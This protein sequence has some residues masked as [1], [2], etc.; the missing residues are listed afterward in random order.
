[1]IW[2]P[3]FPLTAAE[4]HVDYP[5]INDHIDQRRATVER[6]AAPTVKRLAYAVVEFHGL[7]PK[8]IEQQLVTVL[9]RHLDATA[10]FGFEEAQ[11]E[12]RSLRRSRVV[13]PAGGSP[14]ALPLSSEGL[15]VAMVA[16]ATLKK[17]PRGRRGQPIRDAGLYG[18]YARQGL[19]GVL[20]LI[21]LRAQA[22]AAEVAKVAAIYS[23]YAREYEDKVAA[24]AD[25][26][27]RVLHNNVLE[28][29]GESVNNGRTAGALSL[30]DPPTFAM[31]SE[32]LDKATCAA[33]I[34]LQGEIVQVDTPDFYALLPPSGCYG[35]GRC[36][37]VMVFADGVHEIRQPDF[38]QAA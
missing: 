20:A 33:C 15:S 30:P 31:R 13:E 18:R 35:G 22:A 29:V 32:Q 17:P 24:A 5:R 14:P 6:M 34:K 3:R 1:M 27:A 28:L 36:R 12:I 4:K 37:G 38:E 25:A 2:E 21:L 26:A 23:L 19:D 7:R 11:R 9:T 16:T 8:G 10:R